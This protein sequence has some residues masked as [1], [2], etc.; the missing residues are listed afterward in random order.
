MVLN[1]EQGQVQSNSVIL[2]CGV[3]QGSVLGPIHF[4]LYISPLGDIHRKHGIEYHSYADDQQE[5][6]SFGLAI[7]GDKGICLIKLQNCIQDI[8]L[9]MRTNLLKLNDCKMEFVMVRSK[10]N[11]L[12]ADADNTAVQIGDD[13]IA[14]VGTV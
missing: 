4:M 1:G 7:E 2:N 12:K 5:Y 9:W 3:P 10:Q 13:N 14:C 8:R 11:L 6:L